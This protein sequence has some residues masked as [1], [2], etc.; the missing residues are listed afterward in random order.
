M[1]TAKKLKLSTDVKE[2]VLM[3]GNKN[4]L[5]EFIQILGPDFP[6]KVRII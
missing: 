2:I 6:Y 4:K 3:T 1:S 5:S